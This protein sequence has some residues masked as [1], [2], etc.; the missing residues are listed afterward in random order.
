MNVGENIRRIREKQG[1]AQCDLAQ[2]V[3]VS[4]PMICQ[5][6]RGLRGPSLQTGFLIA[7]VLGCTV[8]D[9][10]KDDAS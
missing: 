1:M 5:Y 6:E 7:E 8:E 4:Q 2:K 10:M 3:G 9:L